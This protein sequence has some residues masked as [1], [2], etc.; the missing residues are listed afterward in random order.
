MEH[1]DNIECFACAGCSD[2]IGTLGD[3][4]WY[5]C[6]NC[7]FEQPQQTTPDSEENTE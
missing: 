2:Y 1:T 7:G 6:R 4:D 5:R 3:L